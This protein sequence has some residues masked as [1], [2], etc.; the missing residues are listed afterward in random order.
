MEALL[1][2]GRELA[3]AGEGTITCCAIKI[4]DPSHGIFDTFAIDNARAAQV[5]GKITTALAKE[6]VDLLAREQDIRSVDVVT[7]K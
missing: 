2:A 3:V 5:N 7:V 4:S 1:R 6:S